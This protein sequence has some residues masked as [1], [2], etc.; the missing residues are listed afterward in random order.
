M[1]QLFEMI[2]IKITCSKQLILHLVILIQS[3]SETL[4]TELDNDV[5]KTINI[6][7]EDIILYQVLDPIDLYLLL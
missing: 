6:N 3:F 7:R 4:S 5:I 1:L 2:Y